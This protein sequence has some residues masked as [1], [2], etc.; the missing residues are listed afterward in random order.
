MKVTDITPNRGQ[1]EQRV[2]FAGYG[3]VSTK[4]DEQEH[5]LA[6]QILHFTDYAKEHPGYEL[7]D[8]YADEGITGTDMEKRDELNRMLRDCRMG[9]IDRVICKS[10]SRFARNTEE[11]LV[12]IRMLKEFGVSI[13]FEDKDIDSDK[14]NMEL[15]VTLPGMAVQQ[16]SEAISGY[17]R[18]SIRER[19]ATGEYNCTFPA[20][21]FENSNGE[22]AVKEDEAENV[23]KIFAWYLQGDGMQKIANRLNDSGVPRRYGYT[24]WNQQ[25]V[26]Y[27]LTNERYKGDALLQKQYR[28]ET[29][30]RRQKRNKRE[31]KQY[32][33]E[34]ANPAI[35]DREVYDR[36]QE[37]LKSRKKDACQTEKSALSGK[38]RCPD[39]GGTFR[40]QRLRDKIYWQCEKRSSL[41]T[42]CRSRRV[43]E[44]AVC[45][46][47]TDML[48]KLK[49]YRKEIVCDLIGKLERLQSDQIQNQGVI[50]K[51]DKEIADL[52]AKNLVMTRL[53]TSGAL[54]EADYAQRF[55][56][57]NNRLTELRRERRKQLSYEGDERLTALKELNDILSEYVPSSR[58]DEE[59]FGQIVE[60]VIVDDNAK[61]TFCLYGDLCLTE[62]IPEKR[63]CMHYEEQESSIRLCL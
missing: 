56:E 35:V 54:N 53:H 5:S 42:Q 57:I 6:A 61:I 33:V 9:K 38:L 37:L 28:T 8:V 16:E 4:S 48:Y 34:N 51:I 58:F 10:L 15:F 47:F 59:L 60:K 43:R 44:D 31:K 46:A 7:V 11:L 17:V 26:R 22:L 32:Y 14:L 49:A 36:A 27:V 29:L 1:T 63:R 19:M 30:P 2:R 41:V 18:W 24:V 45:E 25:A 39:C 3:R 55:T 62:T 23:R 12:M 52:S 40:R 50:G 21:G 13:Y 20:Y